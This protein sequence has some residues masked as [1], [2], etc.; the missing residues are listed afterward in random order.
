MARTAAF[1][2]AGMAA[3]FLGAGL[4]GASAQEVLGVWERDTGASRVRFGK[5]GEA[6][7]GT[8]S[9]LKDPNGPAKL[10]QRIFF[11]MKPSGANTWKGSAFNPED[12]KTYSGT[13]TLSGPTLTTAGCVLGGLICRS[14]TWKRTN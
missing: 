5:C 12:G 10:G 14:V 13:M 9:W 6:I 7:C 4:A 3:L 1:G 8:I 2:L 11:D